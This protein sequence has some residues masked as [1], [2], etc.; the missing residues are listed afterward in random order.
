MNSTPLYI[1][2]LSNQDLL[3]QFRIR[4]IQVRYTSEKKTFSNGS[5]TVIYDCNSIKNIVKDG[6][7]LGNSYNF[8]AT[9]TQDGGWFGQQADAIINGISND[10][11]DLMSQKPVTGQT[12]IYK[13]WIEIYAGYGLENDRTSA[14]LVYRGQ[15]YQA[16]PNWSNGQHAFHWDSKATYVTQS[17]QQSNTNGASEESAFSLAK[18]I[19]EKSPVSDGI[20]ANL[21]DGLNF[22]YLKNAH[23]NGSW[24]QQLQQLSTE[25]HL[26]LYLY[27]SEVDLSTYGE[28]FEEKVNVY[29]FKNGL[30]DQPSMQNGV[31]KIKV[32]FNNEI[33]LRQVVYLDDPNIPG[34]YKHTKW[35]VNTIQHVISNQDKAFYTVIGLDYIFYNIPIA[36]SGN[37]TGITANTGYNPNN[38]LSKVMY[39]KDAPNLSASATAQNQVNSNTEQQANVM[40]TTFRQQTS[41]I[42]ALQG[43]WQTNLLGINGLQLG[44]I[45][46][47]NHDKD[48][49]SV[50]ELQIGHMQDGSQRYIA[51]INNV[52]VMKTTGL[53]KYYQDQ[54][55]YVLCTAQDSSNAFQIY[56]KSGKFTPTSVN[57]RRRFSKSDWIILGTPEKNNPIIIKDTDKITIMSNNAQIIVYNNGDIDVKG[58]TVN[59][60]ASTK[61]IVNSKDVELGEGAMQKVLTEGALQISL[62]SLLLTGVTPSPDPTTKATAVITGGIVTV[63]GGSSS[64]KAGKP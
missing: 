33:R 9:I 26:N 30:I 49:Y 18:R 14:K 58:T 43:M 21:S 50:K 46:K 32:F 13:N 44:K 6:V 5:N 45:S 38:I 54:I 22:I 4:Y 53:E 35:V 59:V 31:V 47:V 39:A 60:S 57:S 51:E 3:Q 34:F 40:N 42:D 37:N 48:L 17:D 64:V 27:N 2:H 23:Y 28:I 11:Q 25:A 15:I 12:N 19:I 10:D 8:N 16:D 62:G 55:V 41:L 7:T 20:R 36:T 24:I 61:C 56:N 63:S 52:P 1:S 29:N